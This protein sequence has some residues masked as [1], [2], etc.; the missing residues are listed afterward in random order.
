MNCMWRI[1]LKKMVL[2]ITESP[3]EVCF[4]PPYKV[5]DISMVRLVGMLPFRSYWRRCFTWYLSLQFNNLRRVIMFLLFFDTD[6]ARK[7]TSAA[8]S[9]HHLSAWYSP[10][11]HHKHGPSESWEKKKKKKASPEPPSISAI[12]LFWNGLHCISTR[13]LLAL[14]PTVRFRTVWHLT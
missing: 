10:V 4:I 14:T 2:A 13:V 1:T 3:F 11:H 5:K 7:C 8:V 6:P 9:H 12:L